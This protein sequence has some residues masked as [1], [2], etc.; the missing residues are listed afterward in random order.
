MKLGLKILFISIAVLA[1]V[2]IFGHL[3]L[4][5]QGKALVVEKL[6]SLT[7][8]KVTIENF[9]ITPLFKIEIKNL[10]I[11]DM[12]KVDSLFISPS[13]L[14]FM[15][16]NIAFN[17]IKITSPEFQF[18]KNISRPAD[19]PGSANIGAGISEGVSNNAAAA[20][21]SPKKEIVLKAPVI[22]K[23]LNIQNGR[24][25]YF[26]RSVGVNGIKIIFKDVYFNLA[27]FYL[28]PRSAITNF[29][30]NAKIPWL[31][32][33][34]E[35]KIDFRGWINLYK[36][37]MKASL[38]IKDI[39]G[40]YLYPYYSAWVDLDKARIERANLN[41]TSDINGLN[42]D[43]AAKCHL[44]L[45][46]IVRKER[47]PEERQEKAEQIADTIID[48]FKALN[49]GKI[50]LD[51]TIKT[52][53]DRPEFGFGEIKMAFEDKLNIGLKERR[54]TASD[55]LM[56]PAKVMEGAVKGAADVSKAAIVG[57]TSIGS[58]LKK[59]ILAAFKRQ[60]KVKD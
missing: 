19:L 24:I 17:E 54:L 39:D 59:A 13:V 52:K 30:L 3:F 22:I 6:E 18:E 20:V 8:K 25:N 7:K 23:H 38:S 50:V 1:F 51:F 49:Q 14:G 56:F 44:E 48:V 31:E 2:S 4:V 40:V 36:K 29:E 47:A 37:D 53:M 57:T 55:V 26:D 60:P 58:E 12:A 43:L 34:E 32:G 28:A 21:A 16:G 41:F 42:N 45:T 11:Q 33:Q 46:N 9:A 10:Q 27:N 5:F 15:L 35:G